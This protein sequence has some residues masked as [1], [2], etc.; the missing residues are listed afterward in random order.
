MNIDSLRTPPAVHTHHHNQASGLHAA[1]GAGG[2]DGSGGDGNG[3]DG[4]DQRDPQ[5][6]GG[7]P[8]G[9]LLGG[10]PG[11]PGFPGGGGSDGPNIGGFFARNVDNRGVS[12]LENV[13]II[14]FFQNLQKYI[15]LDRP[16]AIFKHLRDFFTALPALRKTF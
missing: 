8:P 5:V 9:Y 3:P 7:F 10:P 1:Q 6:P 2:P 14:N 13:K 15:K 4:G 11:D 12:S 16:W